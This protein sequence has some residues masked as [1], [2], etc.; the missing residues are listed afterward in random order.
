MAPRP[1][2]GAVLLLAVTPSACTLLDGLGGLTSTGGDDAG[3]DG[4][5]ADAP[6]GTGDVGTTDTGNPGPESGGDAPR[7]V[8]SDSPAD[9][10]TMDVEQDTTPPPDVQEAQPLAYFQV[11][12]ADSPQAYWRLDEPAGSTTAHDATG[13]HDDGTYVGGVT[14]AVQGAIANDQDTAASFDG[15]TAWVDCKNIFQFAGKTAFTLE[16]WV[17]PM[18]DGNYRAWLSRNDPSGP[19]TEG[20][21]A[22]IEPTGDVFSFQ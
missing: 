4:A 14:L 11:V 1:R 15:A 6:A 17:K 8:G 13:N 5:A 22:F 10:T 7:D 18:L 19:P 16:A 12:A 20:Y 9:S 21:L 3:G 2:L